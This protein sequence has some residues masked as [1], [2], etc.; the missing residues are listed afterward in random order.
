MLHS[1]NNAIVAS[2]GITRKINEQYSIL[3]LEWSGSF[4]FSEILE[5]DESAVATELCKFAQNARVLPGLTTSTNRS[6][7]DRVKRAV[8]FNRLKSGQR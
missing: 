5:F 8:Y 1:I 4:Q 3:A 2:V 7:C 6:L